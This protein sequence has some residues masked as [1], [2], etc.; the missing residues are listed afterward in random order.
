MCQ[1][2]SIVC[3]PSVEVPHFALG[4][5]CLSCYFSIVKKLYAVF[6]V[7]NQSTHLIYGLTWYCLDISTLFLVFIYTHTWDVLMLVSLYMQ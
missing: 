5:L 7:L 1:H 2:G 4:P 6:A 3:V